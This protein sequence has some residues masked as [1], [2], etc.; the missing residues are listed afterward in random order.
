MKSIITLAVVV[1]LVYQCT[2]GRFGTDKIFGPP[3]ELPLSRYEDMMVGVW[4]YDSDKSE[5]LYLGQTKGAASCGAVAAS[6][7]QSQRV[8][9]WGYVCC[10]HEA[11]SDCYRKIR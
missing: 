4:F 7:A 2:G 5:N 1:F 8:K 3:S 11:G 6:H 9:N 10:T